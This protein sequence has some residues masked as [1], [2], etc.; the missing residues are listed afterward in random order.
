MFKNTLSYLSQIRSRTRAL[1]ITFV[2]ETEDY[3]IWNKL[4]GLRLLMKHF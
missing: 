2:G 3:L 1:N 4:S